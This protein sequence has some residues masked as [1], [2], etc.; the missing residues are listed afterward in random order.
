[1][2]DSVQTTKWMRI[3]LKLAGVYNLFWGTII[4]L[5]PLDFFLY[6]NLQLP[7]YP[8]IWQ[9]VGMIVGVYG[10]GY[11][12]AAHDPY[13]HWPVILVGFLGKLLGPIGAIYYA[14]IGK[15]PW[16]FLI[17]N[18]FNDFIWLIPFAVILYEGMRKED[19]RVYLR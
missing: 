12:I 9:C 17:V 2:S 19:L 8:E 16:S 5:F 11:Y 15:F 3:T 14:A 1:M 4:V 18:V 13:R 7:N 6:A 10:I